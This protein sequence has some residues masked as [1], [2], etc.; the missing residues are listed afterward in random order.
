MVEGIVESF[1]GARVGRF[2]TLADRDPC[3]V[4][5]VAG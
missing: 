2:A 5:L 4:D 3:Q 1:G